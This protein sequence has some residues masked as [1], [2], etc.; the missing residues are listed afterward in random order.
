[1]S[2]QRKHLRKITF[3]GILAAF[4]FIGTE[5]HVPTAIGHVNLGD[6]VIL[7]SAFILGPIAAIP[8]AIG[9]ALADLLAG[10]PQYI[11]PTFIIKGLMGLVAG[12]IMRRKP[13]GNVSLPRKLIAAVVAESIMIGGYFAFESLMYG[14]TAA[15]G[16]LIPNLIQATAAIVGAIPLTYI[17]SFNNVKV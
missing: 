17:K 1:M 9:S 11:A 5:I 7:V 15:T 3:A 12:L 14:V 2:D 8:A 16:S 6:V 13:H 4:I 10:Y